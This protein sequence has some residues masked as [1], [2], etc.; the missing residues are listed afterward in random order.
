M[1]TGFTVLV[2]HPKAGWN[3]ALA[4]RPEGTEDLADA[5]LARLVVAK[6][7]R[8]GTLVVTEQTPSRTQLSIWTAPALPLLEGLIVNTEIDA[9]TRKKLKPIVDRRREVA[10]LEE[11]IEGL[12]GRRDKLDQ[13]ANEL[14]SNLVAIAKNPAAGSQ[15]TKWTKQ[16]EEFTTEGNKLGAQLADL[17]AKRLDQRIELENLLQELEITP[18]AAPAPK[19]ARP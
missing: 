18:P 9:D 13:R 11:Q 6:G 2:R 7:S 19:P 15:R 17:E 10:K 4:S 12:T 5:Y 14:R 1:D 16:L 8:E 3:Y